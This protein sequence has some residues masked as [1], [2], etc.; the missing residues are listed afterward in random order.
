[1]RQIVLASLLGLAACSTPYERC[2]RDAANLYSQAMR[3]RAE[4]AKDLARGFTYSTEWETR[5]RWDVCGSH[6]GYLHY[7]WRHDTEPVTRRVPINAEEL[8]R[9]DAALEEQIPQL[10]RDAAAG[11]SECRKRYPAEVEAAL[12]ASSSKG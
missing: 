6:H 10:R 3:E 2:N 9:R 8:R 7:C 12:P 11:Q 1:M 4:I 5:L